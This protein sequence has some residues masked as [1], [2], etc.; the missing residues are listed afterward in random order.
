MHEAHVS[1]QSRRAL[2]VFVRGI[3]EN[4]EAQKKAQ[5]EIDSVIRLGDLPDVV[6]LV[7]GKYQLKTSISIRPENGRSVCP[8]KEIAYDTLWIMAASILATFDITKAVGDDGEIIE[9]TLGHT[10]EL[11]E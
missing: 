2:R 3:L 4:P 6:V 1:P 9:P 5:Q 8:G 7:G 10:S 11:V